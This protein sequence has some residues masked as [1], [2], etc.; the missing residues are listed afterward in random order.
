MQ[1]PSPE[2]DFLTNLFRNLDENACGY[3]VMRNY[4]A[5][6]FSHDGSDLD[7][8]IKSGDEKGVQH[9]IDSALALSNAVRLGTSFAPGF[10]KVSVLGHNVSHENGWWGLR[11]DINV[12]LF[13]QGLPLLDDSGELAVEQHQSIKV[14]PAGLAAVLGVLKEA[15]NNSLVPERYLAQARVAAERDWHAIQTLLAPMGPDA[16]GA[17]RQLI[18]E[19][20]VGTRHACKAIRRSFY[21]HQL[22]QSPA[23]FFTSRLQSFLSKLVRYIKPSGIVVA[24]LGTDGA[25]KSTIIDAITP[26]LDQATHNATVLRHLRPDLLPPLGRLKGAGNLPAGPVIDPHGSRPSGFWGSLARVVYATAN[27]ILGYWFE[28]RL[29]I[30]KQP[31]VVIFDRYA[32]DMLLDQRRFRI[33]LPS[34]LVHFFVWLAPKPDLIFCLH[35]DPAVLAA[36]KNELP[37]TE[38]TRQVEALRT[39]AANE[40]RAVLVSTEGTVEQ[41]RDEILQALMEHARKKQANKR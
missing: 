3:A 28:T 30:A 32:Y 34:W 13:F 24:I 19:R 21:R 29:Q 12:G 20:L 4:K 11:I 31:T 23:G 26:A 37:L 39:F 8:L 5:L 22:L 40:P 1:N 10:F 7:I 6:P 33:S 38:V 18:L 25:G 2:Y 41:A 15:L 35:G 27:Y 17:F 9:A 14:L 16:L 36:R